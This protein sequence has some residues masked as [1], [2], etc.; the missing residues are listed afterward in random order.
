MSGQAGGGMTVG[1]LIEAMGGI[2]PDTP[3]H[4][5]LDL[6]KVGDSCSFHHIRELHETCCGGVEIVVYEAY[7]LF[8][9]DS[10]PPEITAGL[11]G[12]PELADVL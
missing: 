6:G 5:C 1:E 8:D 9:L 10:S 3:V 7:D 12:I 4:V 11:L 2:D